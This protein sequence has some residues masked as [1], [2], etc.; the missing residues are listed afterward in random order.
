MIVKYF[1]LARVFFFFQV[2]VANPKKPPEIISILAKNHD[3]LLIVL[4]NLPINKGE[5][6]CIFVWFK[7]IF[8]YFYLFQ[9]FSSGLLLFFTHVRGL[10]SI[11]LGG[12][13]EQ[14]EEERDLVV[15]EIQRI[16]HLPNAIC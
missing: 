4:E 15:K 8:C 3:K 14:L 2:F 7:R 13:D 16:P 11:L 12:E 6:F 1:P 10:H 9:P 5:Y